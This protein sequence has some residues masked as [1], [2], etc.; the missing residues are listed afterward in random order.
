[1]KQSFGKKLTSQR[2]WAH[3]MYTMCLYLFILQSE[4][5]LSKA[6]ITVKINE[7]NSVVVC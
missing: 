5:L 4:S 6:M 3:K 2:P 7:T 1:M